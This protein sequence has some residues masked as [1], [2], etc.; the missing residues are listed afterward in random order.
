M[1]REEFLALGRELS[2]RKERMLFP[3]IDPEA[4]AAAKENDEA[5][6]GYV[7]PIDD[8]LRRLEAEGMKVVLS[9]Q[10]GNLDVFIM[11]FA[12]GDIAVDTLLPRHLSLAAEM[13]EPLRR[14]ISASRRY[15]K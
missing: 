8:L 4:Y 10:A 15:R 3:G 12:S 1:Q 2:E 6:P 14:L 13:E 9:D 7:T 11:P 5:F